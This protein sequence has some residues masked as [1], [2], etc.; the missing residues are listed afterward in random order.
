MSSSFKGKDLFGSG[1]HR[2]AVGKLG[3]F[4]VSDFTLGIYDGGTTPLGL[5]EL[6]VI[7]T[8]RLVATNDTALWA[9]RDAIEAELVHLPTAGTLV[10]LHGRTWEGM[11]FIRFESADR[12]D[13]GRDVSLAYEAQF[14]K[15]HS[16]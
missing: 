14:R 6:D 9:L 2:F 13:R 1:P 10:D 15:F 4:I 8:G 11:S 3:E 12:T 5:V 16:L 7:V